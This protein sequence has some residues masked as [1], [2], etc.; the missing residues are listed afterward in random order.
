MF[1]VKLYYIICITYVHFN[2]NVRRFCKK[3]TDVL[4]KKYGRF[5]EKVRTFLGKSTDVLGEKYGRFFETFHCFL[6]IA[7]YQTLTNERKK[8]TKNSPKYKRKRMKKAI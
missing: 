2:E 6:Y 1:L 7:N 4:I 3:S 8:T 5:W